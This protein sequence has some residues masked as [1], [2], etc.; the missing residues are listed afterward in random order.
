MGSAPKKCP[1]IAGGALRGPY[2]IFILKAVWQSQIMHLITQK[3]I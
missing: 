1:K 3:K 2:V